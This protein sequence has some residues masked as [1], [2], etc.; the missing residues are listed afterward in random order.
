MVGLVGGIY[1]PPPPPS[2]IRSNRL[3]SAPKNG[4]AG[5]TAVELA[6]A[7]NSARKRVPKKGL[8]AWVFLGV[9]YDHDDDDIE[10]DGPK[11]VS[12]CTSRVITSSREFPWEALSDT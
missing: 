11:E 6:V 9:G 5:S 8:L 4:D 3:L 1:I 7:S 12:P 10:V 2:S